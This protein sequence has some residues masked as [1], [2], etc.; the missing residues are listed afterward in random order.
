M[1][2]PLLIRILTV[3]L[4][5]INVPALVAQFAPS[6]NAFNYAIANTTITSGTLPFASSGS[7]TIAFSQG[8]LF[9]YNI[10]GSQLTPAIEIY[11]CTQ[12]GP[13]T[14]TI[15]L[16]RTNITPQFSAQ[17]VWTFTS[18]NAGRF[19]TSGTYNGYT[20]SAQGTFTI[21]FLQPVSDRLI[22]I[23]TRGFVG[24]GSQTLIGGFVVSGPSTEVYFKA[25]DPNDPELKQA[26]TI[27]IT[28]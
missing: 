21:T 22:N 12:T 8:N 14:E 2:T 6:A 4:F 10:G 1:K 26:H 28:R 5:L 24:T 15:V 18:P 27:E 9:T 20:G 3:S 19:S 17:Q 16:T 11:S 25:L 7:A 23:S 13:N